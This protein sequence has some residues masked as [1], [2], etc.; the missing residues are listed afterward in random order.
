[1][2]PAAQPRTLTTRASERCQRVASKTL[3]ARL[4][5]LAWCS[6]HC[7]PLILF[8]VLLVFHPPF[9]I[10]PLIFALPLKPVQS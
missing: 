8:G 2:L 4:L 1:M 10:Y 7:H 5:Q 3:K 6:Q 9:L